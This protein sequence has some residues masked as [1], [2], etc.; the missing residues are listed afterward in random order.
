MLTTLK[1][2]RKLAI[3]ARQTHRTHPVLH[4]LWTI[5][6]LQVNF[7]LLVLT[8][9]NWWG[10]LSGPVHQVDLVLYITI[11]LL[12]CAVFV[13][14]LLA[15]RQTKIHPY[16]N[17]NSEPKDKDSPQV[18]KTASDGSTWSGFC[19]KLCRLV[20]YMWPSNYPLLQMKVRVILLLL[21][22]VRVA[23]VLCLCSIRRW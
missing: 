7:R 18:G 20:P 11:Y 6:F 14:G 8:K 22:L 5:S 17:L 2:N 10:D 19:R 16:N 21:M 4:V 1:Q 3:S 12:T 23:N 15:D 13:L 9:E